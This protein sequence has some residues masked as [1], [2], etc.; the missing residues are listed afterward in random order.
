MGKAAIV[1][2]AVRSVISAD[3]KTNLSINCGLSLQAASQA[4]ASKSAH[5][6]APLVEVVLVA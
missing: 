2:F 3:K 5:T 6:N 1:L 4:G